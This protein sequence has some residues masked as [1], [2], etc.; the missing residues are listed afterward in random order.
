[1]HVGFF[2]PRTVAEAYRAAGL[3]PTAGKYI[4][5]FTEMLRYKIL[6]N[7][8]IRN[9]SWMEASIPWA[10]GPPARRS[11]PSTL[12]DPAGRGTGRRWTAADRPGT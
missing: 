6:K 5:G 8:R 11:A 3:L 1:M 2:E 10:C 9:R 12:P 4:P 7:L